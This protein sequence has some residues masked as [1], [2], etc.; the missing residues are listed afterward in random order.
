MYWP[1]PIKDTIKWFTFP[2]IIE[3]TT[4]ILKP[5]KGLIPSLLKVFAMFPLRLFDNKQ[6]EEGEF[7]CIIATR[8]INF[9][10]ETGLYLINTIIE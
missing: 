5:N 9:N 7:V 1:I 6:D 4:T 2:T 10:K 8:C 3:H